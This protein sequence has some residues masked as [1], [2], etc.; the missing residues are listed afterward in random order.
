MLNAITCTL[1]ESY[2]GYYLQVKRMKVCVFSSVTTPLTMVIIIIKNI[3]A[4]LTN[5]IL[6]ANIYKNYNT[7][8]RPRDP[9]PDVEAALL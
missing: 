5:S 7:G 3:F 9:N 2:L 8:P 4:L 6:S 1:V